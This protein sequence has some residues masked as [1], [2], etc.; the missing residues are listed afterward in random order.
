MNSPHLFGRNA[1]VEKNKYTRANGIKLLIEFECN[2]IF[3]T[4]MRTIQHI[5]T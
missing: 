5:P 4:L 1:P 2:G 3:G